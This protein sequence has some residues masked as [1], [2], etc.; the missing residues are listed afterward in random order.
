MSGLQQLDLSGYD[1]QRPV[2]RQDDGPDPLDFVV[3]LTRTRAGHD[4]YVCTAYPAPPEAVA[5][6]NKDG[7]PLFTPPEIE[8]MKGC[9][10]QLVEQVL[11]IKRQFPGSVV[12]LATM[13]VAG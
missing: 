10:P 11:A 12:D 5:L 9:D 4:I 1:A 8:Q 6:A 2:L 3:R 7:I 13:E